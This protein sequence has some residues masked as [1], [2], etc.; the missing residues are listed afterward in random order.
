MLYLNGGATAEI[1]E[2]YRGHEK[3]LQGGFFLIK[4]KRTSA[5]HDGSGSKSIGEIVHADD[6]TSKGW[7]TTGD[8]RADGG[9]REIH[10]ACD[11]APE[12]SPENPGP[13]MHYYWPRCFDKK[14]NW[15]EKA[16]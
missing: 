3:E 8:L 12:G 1:V 6:R 7:T 5:Y 10:E 14:G 11:K 15:I 9:L 16:A 13:I 2:C 4:I